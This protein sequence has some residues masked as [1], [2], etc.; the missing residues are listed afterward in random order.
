MIKQA[1]NATYNID[2]LPLEVVGMLNVLFKG[3]IEGFENAYMVEIKL[4]DPIK[5]IEEGD[6]FFII[7]SSIDQYE[8]NAEHC[9]DYD[10]AVIHKKMFK[11]L[12]EADEKRFETLLKK[13]F[14]A[15]KIAEKKEEPKTNPVR[16][17]RR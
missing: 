5:H 3:K 6:E 4:D 2:K 14:E 13:Y 16:Q 8:S 12:I 11:N 7:H 15:D 1:N 10:W 17:R 9:W